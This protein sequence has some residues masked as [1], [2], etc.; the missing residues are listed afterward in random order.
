MRY[1][2]Q[3][4]A[5]AAR[6]SISLPYELHNAIWKCICFRDF[7]M[8]AGKRTW[9][10][11]WGIK[12]SMISSSGVKARPMRRLHV[13]TIWRCML[14]CER[15][16]A[17]EL[18]WPKVCPKSEEATIYGTCIYKPRHEPDL[19]KIWGNHK[20]V[21]AWEPCSCDAFCWHSQ[22]SFAICPTLL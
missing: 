9:R 13:T 11:K 5:C 15:N 19:H 7:S 17:L 18:R 3:L 4:L 20:Y 21:N 14:C 16:N 8:A 10:P 2:K 22:L 1:T 12:I 6:W